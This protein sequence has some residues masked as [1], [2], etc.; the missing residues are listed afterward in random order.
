MKTQVMVIMITTDYPHENKRV[1][2]WLIGFVG[3]FVIWKQERKGQGS[4]ELS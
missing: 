1:K 2:E 4:K 3:F